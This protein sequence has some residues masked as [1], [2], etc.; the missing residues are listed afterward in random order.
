[1]KGVKTISAIKAR[2][3]LGQLLEEVYYQGAQYIIERAG[4]PMAAVVPLPEL[5][6]LQEQRAPITT[7]KHG[8][9]GAAAT[10]RNSRTKG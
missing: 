10:K 8:P 6:K 5:E 7:M 1:M 4:R 9:E 2:K 3:N